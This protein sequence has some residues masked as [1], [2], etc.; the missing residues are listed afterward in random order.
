MVH[1]KIGKLLQV[2]HYF[3]TVASLWVELTSHRQLQTAQCTMQH[4]TVFSTIKAI[5]CQNSGLH[6]PDF[7][8]IFILQSDALES[9]CPRPFRIM[10]T[11]IISES[12]PRIWVFSNWEWASS[13]L[14]CCGISHILCF[15]KSLCPRY[16]SSLTYAS[17][18]LGRTPLLCWVVESGHTVLCLSGADF[19]LVW[20][21]SRDWCRTDASNFQRALIQRTVS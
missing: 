19:S 13:N 20:V 4:D 5:L 21:N 2:F 12:S 1:F 8:Q 18:I 14:I 11:H 7:T 15:R 6:F 10:N 9:P 17:F 3:A 16:G